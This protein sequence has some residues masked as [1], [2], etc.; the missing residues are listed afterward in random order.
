MKINSKT[1]TT[2]VKKTGV[3]KEVKKQVSKKSVGK[4]TKEELENMFNFDFGCD[5]S[6]CPHHCGGDE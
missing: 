3:Q 4:K 1:K 6:T 5:C 2:A